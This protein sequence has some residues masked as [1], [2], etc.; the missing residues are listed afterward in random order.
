[1]KRVGLTGNTLLARPMRSPRRGIIDPVFATACTL[2]ALSFCNL[3][4]GSGGNATLLALRETNRTR[5]A[6]IDC[7]LSPRETNRRLQTLGLSIDKISDVF[8]T[9]LDGDHFYPSWVKCC[10]RY[11]MKIHLHRRQQ[12]RAALLG[13][14]F[15]CVELFDDEFGFGSETHVEAVPFAHDALGTVGFVITHRDLRLGFATDLGRVPSHLY[16]RFINLHAL[17][18]E[19][20]YDR[21]MQLASP[22]PIFLK[23]RIMNGSGHL[24]NEQSLE[25]VMRIASQSNLSHVALLHLSRQCNCPKLVRRLYAERVPELLPKLVVTSQFSPSPVLTVNAKGE[26]LLRSAPPGCAAPQ[27][28]LYERASRS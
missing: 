21:D 22:R 15:R 2:M 12:R 23:Q 9:H 13:M 19:S 25:A 1:M 4:S 11:G 8:V 3:G 6:L 24:S 14:N 5:F 18:L 27:G 7:G 16:E 20:N 17:A 28:M 10:E 26:P